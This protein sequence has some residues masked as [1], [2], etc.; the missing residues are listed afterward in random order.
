MNSEGLSSKFDELRHRFYM[1]QVL[2]HVQAYRE[3]FF[4]TLRS[5]SL[6]HRKIHSITVNKDL[7]TYIK[8]TWIWGTICT[9]S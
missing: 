8:N 4:E 6:F 5:S 3:V 9:K 7:L 2:Y 1:L